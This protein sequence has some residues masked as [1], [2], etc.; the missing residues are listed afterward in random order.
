MSG[1]TPETMKMF[2]VGPQGHVEAGSIT[3]RPHRGQWEYFLSDNA[4]I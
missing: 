4:N 1:G 3:H 2:H